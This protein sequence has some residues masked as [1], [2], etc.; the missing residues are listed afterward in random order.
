MQALEG[1]WQPLSEALRPEEARVAT[2]L[3]VHLSVSVPEAQRRV[4]VK[5]PRLC[6]KCRGKVRPN[7]GSTV[8]AWWCPRCESA[9]SDV[10]IQQFPG[11]NPDAKVIHLSDRRREAKRGKG[12]R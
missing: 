7:D 6:P 11:N 1:E 2:D 8:G 9:Y 4:V 3:Q 5:Y 12:G 10:E